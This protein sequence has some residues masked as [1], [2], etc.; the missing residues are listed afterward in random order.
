MACKGARRK[1]AKAEILMAEQAK[2]KMN[3]SY[4]ASGIADKISK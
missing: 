2:A 4:V 3:E 1:Q